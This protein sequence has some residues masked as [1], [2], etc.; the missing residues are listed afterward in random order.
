MGTAEGAGEN[1]KPADT[2]ARRIR[3]GNARDYRNSGSRA[4]RQATARGKK[5][6]FRPPRPEFSV[7]R[8]KA[9]PGSSILHFARAMLAED[10]ASSGGRVET[11]APVAGCRRKAGP[12][13]PPKESPPAENLIFLS[14]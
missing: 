6:G 8:E 14:V 11:R 10:I 9:F 2:K 7:C 4:A 1:M 3:R 13:F 12:G 5:R